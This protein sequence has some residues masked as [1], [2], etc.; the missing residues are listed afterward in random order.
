M[1]LGWVR[2]DRFPSQ[3]EN[4]S[5]ETDSHPAGQAAEVSRSGV[6]G[7]ARKITCNGLARVGLKASG[8]CAVLMF[9]EW[10]GMIP[11]QNFFKGGSSSIPARCGG[12]N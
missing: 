1:L 10:L 12:P 2:S 6:E 9:E 3:V 4:L 5:P 7:A 8:Q 11:T